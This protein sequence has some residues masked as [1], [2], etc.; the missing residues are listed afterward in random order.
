MPDRKKF[1]KNLLRIGLVNLIWLFYLLGTC[2]E[3]SAD[4]TALCNG[5]VLVIVGLFVFLRV[6][7]EFF[8]SLLT[9]NTF[10]FLWLGYLV[11]VAIMDLFF[12]VTR[13]DSLVLISIRGL[14]NGGKLESEDGFFAGYLNAF[15]LI[16]IVFW[17]TEEGLK[18]M[19]ISGG[20]N[21]HIY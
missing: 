9:V 19:R 3:G 21:N 16:A 4:Y 15:V 17:I 7:V 6:A 5:I 10:T 14:M 20:P 11:Q 12:L 2:G 1:F 8:L 13:H 18:K